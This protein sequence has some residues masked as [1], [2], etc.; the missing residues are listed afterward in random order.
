MTAIRINP[1]VV[2]VSPTGTSQIHRISPTQ[3]GGGVKKVI[4]VVAAVAIPIAAPAIASSIAASGVL[5]AAVST[6]MTSTVGAAVSSAVVGAGLGAITAKVTGGDVKTGAIMGGLGGAIGGYGAA[7]AGTFGTPAGGVKAT[8]DRV[9]GTNFSGTSGLAEGQSS[10]TGMEGAG[11]D[12]LVQASADG[13]NTLSN[14]NN[15]GLTTTDQTTLTNLNTANTSG[16][17]AAQL[18]NANV[19]PGSMGGASVQNAVATG[20]GDVVN[21]AVGTG[22]TETAS[23]GTRF[24]E[25]VK[26]AGSVVA[27]K[28]TDP[29]ALANLTMQAGAQVL[30]AALAPDPEMPPEQR[31]LLEMRKQELQE[32]K[33][34]DEA[35][36]NAQMDAA[37]QFLQQA[38]QYDP[39]YMAFQAAN[40]EAIDQQRKLREQQRK[41]ALSSGRGISEAEK[42]RMSLD[43]ARNVSSEYDKGFQQGLSGQ[44]KITQAGLSAIPN[45]AQ[46]ATYTDALN[47]LTDDARQVETGMYSGTKGKNIADLFAGFNVDQGDVDEVIAQREADKK[48]KAGLNT[49]NFGTIAV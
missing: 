36:F 15:A 27:N 24:M 6:A 47:E 12:G 34:R 43:A 45:S 38:K 1:M 25:G 28:L 17:V 14:I 9:L 13:S 31:E 4:A 23:F 49:N 26:T 7:K 39:T 3:H 33:T 37:K 44:T 40:K 19:G 35:A 10:L 41:Y 18:S 30:G 11:Q 21:A 32:L 16:D 46:F 20:T 42:R 2:S 5:G 48:R 22:A 29:E 8:A